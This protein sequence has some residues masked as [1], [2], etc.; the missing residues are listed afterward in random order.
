MQLIDPAMPQEAERLIAAVAAGR[1]RTIYRYIRLMAAAV[2]ALG[3]LALVWWLTPLRE[4]INIHRAVAAM[5]ALGDSP[6][7]PLVMLAAFL[8]G[9]LL[10]IPVNVLIAI[11]VLVFGPLPGALYA[12]LGVELSGALVY[13]IGRHFPAGELRARLERNTQRLRARLDKHGLLAV[14]LVR[15]V[16]VAPYTVVNLAGGAMRVPRVQYLVGTALGMLPGIVFNALFIDRVVEAIERPNPWS[17]ALL[18]GA[19]ALIVA[20]IVLIRRRVARAHA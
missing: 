18:I 15:I 2:I 7:A 17:Y 9:G 5:N 1:R 12:L 8:I 14:A 16:P 13:E 11:T 3:T 19:A 4:W 20:A 10:M 6:T